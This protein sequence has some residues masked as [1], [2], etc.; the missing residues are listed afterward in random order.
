MCT[1]HKAGK[2]NIKTLLIAVWFS[3]LVAPFQK[4]KYIAILSKYAN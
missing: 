2:S 3:I 1:G 4:I